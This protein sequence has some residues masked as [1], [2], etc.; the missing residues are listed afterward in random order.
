MRGGLERSAKEI[1]DTERRYLD[2]LGAK[3]E[4][5]EGK[6]ILDVG[7]NNVAFQRAARQHDA[8]VT[9]FDKYADREEWEQD[10][11]SPDEED[12]FVQGLAEKM[13]F[14]ENSFDVVICHA[15][16]FVLTSNRDSIEVM[17]SEA[18]RVL[19][20]G[21]ELRVGRTFILPKEE[22]TPFEGQ[23]L[24]IVGRQN[25]L[26]ARA[27]Q[28]IQDIAQK[29]HFEIAEFRMHKRNREGFAYCHYVL[30]KPLVIA[31]ETA[32]G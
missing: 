7:A 29:Y 26:Q 22:E 5:F 13:P 24:K 1:K 23:E 3:W 25:M 31:G 6:K 10:G 9:S 14:S 20:P 27:R 18:Q 30:R 19:N 16:P 12:K 2:G 21:G 11:L 32:G 28:F 4:N 8:E 15:G 17:F